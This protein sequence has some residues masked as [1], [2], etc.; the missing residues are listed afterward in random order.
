MP[1]SLLLCLN[2]WIPT[3]VL[4]RH[5]YGLLF[6]T[7]DTHLFVMGLLTLNFDTANVETEVPSTAD[8]RLCQIAYH[9]VKCPE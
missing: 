5:C 1:T 2:S 9:S 7:F 4:S 3:S 8:L 6:Q